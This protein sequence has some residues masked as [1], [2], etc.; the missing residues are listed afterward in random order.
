M[1]ADS[2]M[3]VVS[4]GSLIIEWSASILPSTV[5][6]AAVD[7]WTCLSLASPTSCSLLAANKSPSQA[8]VTWAPLPPLTTTVAPSEPYLVVVAPAGTPA[9]RFPAIDLPA[10]SFNASASPPDWSTVR[11]SHVEVWAPQGSL[12]PGVLS[13]GTLDMLQ[14]SHL[15]A[16]ASSTPPPSSSQPSDGS[17]TSSMPSGTIAGVCAGIIMAVLALAFCV[18]RQRHAKKT[19]SLP[20]AQAA[21]MYGKDDASPTFGSFGANHTA[22]GSLAEPPSP[23]PLLDQPPPTPHRPPS[24]GSTSSITNPFVRPATP[25]PKL[26]LQLGRLVIPAAQDAALSP[27]S[28]TS[29]AST[30][31]NYT[32]HVASCRMPPPLPRARALPS[33]ARER[34]RRPPTPTAAHPLLPDKKPMPTTPKSPAAVSPDSPMSEAPSPTAYDGKPVH[35]HAGYVEALDNFLSVSPPLSLH[36]TIGRSNNNNPGSTTA[37]TSPSGHLQIPGLLA[38]RP[39]LKTRLLRTSSSRGSLDRR[40]QS[41]VGSASINIS[42]SSDSF[43][44]QPDIVDLSGDAGPPQ[45]ESA[46]N[47]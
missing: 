39:S 27:M 13:N 31:S 44:E 1:S 4:G 19:S 11:W 33:P 38:H 2:I 15:Q 26:D 3:Q 30:Y 14:M 6:N 5:S 34:H 37:S 42:E 9:R 20:M 40:R 18:R 25:R 47:T 8:S 36:L 29:P 23:T 10:T 24:H 32:T 21:T 45:L 17:K 41:S 16:A 22:I 12:P 46:K 28:P 7:V 35:L 43:N